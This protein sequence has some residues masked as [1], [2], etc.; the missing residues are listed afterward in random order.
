MDL[1][2]GIPA[3]VTTLDR[4]D[5]G[6]L[7]GRFSEDV[8]RIACLVDEAL[9]D[10]QTFGAQVARNRGLKVDIFSDEGEALRWLRTDGLRGFRPVRPGERKD[11]GSGVSRPAR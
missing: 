1:R 5:L 2:P 4:Y 9:V 6:V 7:G 10:P 11:G 3:T 8:G